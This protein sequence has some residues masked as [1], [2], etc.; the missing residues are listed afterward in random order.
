[1]HVYA[2]YYLG[3]I[4]INYRIPVTSGNGRIEG[5]KRKEE[6]ALLV[7]ICLF[8]YKIRNLFKRIQC[9]NKTPLFI[10]SR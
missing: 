1:M 3:M 6:V 9:Y 8:F 7:R 2:L 5:W 4:Y 10:K